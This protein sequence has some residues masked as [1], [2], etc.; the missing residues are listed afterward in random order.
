[1]SEFKEN[2]RPELEDIIIS[3]LTGDAQQNALNFAVFLAAN[4]ILPCGDHGEVSYKGHPLC[5]MHLD[6]DEQ[7]PGPWTIWT[8]GDY[9]VEYKN[10]PISG[11]IKEIAWKNVNICASCGSDCAP[12]SSKN[13]FGKDFENVCGAILAFTD[14]EVETLKCLKQLIE[15][16]KTYKPE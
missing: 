14:P 11:N 16:V 4:E 12:G 15:L 5:Y 3:S 7:K 2:L 10:V 1:M 13:I 6:S 9:S 8:E